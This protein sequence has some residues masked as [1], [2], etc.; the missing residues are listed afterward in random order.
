MGEGIQDLD[1]YSQGRLAAE[2]TL[3]ESRRQADKKREITEKDSV[4]CDEHAMAGSVAKRLAKSRPLML[5]ITKLGLLS[6]PE[7]DQEG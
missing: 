1:R 2:R 4:A 3:P 7:G 6:D 5:F